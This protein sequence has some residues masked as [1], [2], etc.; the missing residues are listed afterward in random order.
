MRLINDTDKKDIRALVKQFGVK[1]VRQMRLRRAPVHIGK[2][3]EW[4]PTDKAIALLNALEGAGY[5]LG[6]RQTSFELAEKGLL[7]TVI[8]EGVK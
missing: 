6:M 1:S 3:C 5:V 7:D 4:I 2:Q 8:L